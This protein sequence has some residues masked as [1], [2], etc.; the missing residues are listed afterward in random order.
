MAHGTLGVA[1]NPAANCGFQ[2]RRAGGPGAAGT[3]SVSGT[4]GLLVSG[5]RPIHKIPR[6]AK[7]ATHLCYRGIR[8]L[9]A[10]DGPA[11]FLGWK[12]GWHG[13]HLAVRR[14]VTF[15]LIKARLVN[16]F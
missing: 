15:C 5:P 4:L 12:E 8:H 10:D 1:G 13:V 14:S 11:N 3:E 16:I 6:A 9:H 7:R 2:L